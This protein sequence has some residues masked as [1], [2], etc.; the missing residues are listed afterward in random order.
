M[1]GDEIDSAMEDSSK[2]DAC[3]TSKPWWMSRTVIGVLIAAAAGLASR[4][5]IQID[6]RAMTDIALIVGGAGLAIY[7][8]TK[9]TTPIR[10][11]NRKTVPGGPFNPDAEVR[12]AI[13]VSGGRGGNDKGHAL[14]V[15]MPIIGLVIVFLL[16]A[17][18]YLMLGGCVM[19]TTQ[20]TGRGTERVN[21]AGVWPLVTYT[22]VSGNRTDVPKVSPTPSPSPV[23]DVIDEQPDLSAAG[24]LPRP[25]DG[26]R[27]LPEDLLRFVHV[28]EAPVLQRLLTGIRPTF[29]VSESGTRVA[30]DEHGVTVLGSASTDDFGAYALSQWDA[31][32][33][34]NDYAVGIKTGTECW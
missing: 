26:T 10:F 34:A 3:A 19:Y 5:G 16:G 15:L 18:F 24:T 14:D 27:A 6:V 11:T 28:D 30:V 23:P 7:G 22:W 8:R 29:E 12:K 17:M 31:W 1:N 4:W 2:Q 21:A 25:R 13:P 33:S 20:R 9:A 32:R